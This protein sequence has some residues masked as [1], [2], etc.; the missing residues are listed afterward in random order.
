MAGYFNCGGYDDPGWNSG[1]CRNSGRRRKY[2]ADSGNIS[3]NAECDNRDTEGRNIGR[4]A[5]CDSRNTK[6]RNISRN[7]GYDGRNT[8]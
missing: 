6:G 2:R 1:K 3:R 5:G 4:N 8:E 7:A